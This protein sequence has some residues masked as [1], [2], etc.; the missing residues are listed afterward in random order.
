M[1]FKLLASA[2][3]NDIILPQQA[4]AF[5]QSR[6]SYWAQQANDVIP[7]CIVRPRNAQQLSTALTILKQEYDK[8]PK[9]LFAVRSGGHNQ[10]SGASS[11]E[12]GVLI[13]LS[14]F[15]EVMLS[16]DKSSV[17]IGAGA[18]WKDVSERLEE[19]GVAVVGGRNS[20]VGIGGLALGGQFQFSIYSFLSFD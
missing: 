4:D 5:K 18:K 15:P 2:L 13:D 12:G 16:Q 6:N 17:I 19:K 1:L 20:Q 7:S 10:V 8:T 3:P 11:I 14:L 9:A